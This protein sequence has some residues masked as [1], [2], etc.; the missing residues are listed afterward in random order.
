ME[1]CPTLSMFSFG[2]TGERAIAKK[3]IVEPFFLFCS[4]EISFQ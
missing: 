1:V 4:S 3:K 2:V